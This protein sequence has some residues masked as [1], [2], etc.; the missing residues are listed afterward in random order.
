MPPLW[1]VTMT[2]IPRSAQP[3]G[4]CPRRRALRSNRSF[5]RN[6]YLGLHHLSRSVDGATVSSVM[7]IYPEDTGRFPKTQRLQLCLPIHQVVICIK[8]MRSVRNRRRDSSI[9]AMPRSLPSV[10][11]LVARNVAL[12]V[13]VSANSSPMT[14]SARPYIGDASTTFASASNI[15]RSISR[16]GIQ[17]DDG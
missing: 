3:V 7:P 9:C 6:R 14:P 10:Q 8:S 11:T 1:A 16:C 4:A 5:G 13:S 17:A 12:R 15:I 2:A